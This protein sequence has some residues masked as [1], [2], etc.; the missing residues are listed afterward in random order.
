M[1]VEEIEARAVLL[2]VPITGDHWKA[3]AAPACRNLW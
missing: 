2:L 3:L 1:S